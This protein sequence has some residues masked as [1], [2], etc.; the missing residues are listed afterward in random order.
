MFGSSTRRRFLQSTAAGGA[1]CGLGDL[2]FL[3][4]L[5]PVS[6]AEAAPD[7]RVVQLRPEIEPLVR[8]LEET[9]RDRLLEEV[10]ARI[11][12]GTT[13]TE[14]LAALLLAGVR[15]VQPR[16]SV[17]FKFHAV[18][19]VN[20]AHLA[21]MASPD[22]HRW[23]PIF[24][25]L[26][27]FKSSQAR[28]VEENDWTMAPVDEAKV[29]GAAAAR[30][31]FVKAMDNWD[32]E[33]ADAAV[34]GLARTAGANEVFELFFRYGARDFR[35]IGHKAI[36]VANSWRTLQCIGWQHAEPVLRSLAYALQ[37]HEGDNPAR[38]DTEADLP[39]RRNLELAG[40]IQ[41]DWLEGRVDDDATRDMLSVLREGTHEDACDKT[42]ELLNAG[43]SAQSVWDAILCGAG[44]LL[45]CQPGIVALHA[46]TSSN[47]LRFAFQASGDDQTRRMMLLQNAAFVPLFRQ[48]AR[49]RGD[50]K[51]VR[52]DQLQPGDVTANETEA[53]DEIFAAVSSDRMAAAGKVLAHLAR[54]ATPTSLIDAARVLVFL[55]GRDSHDYKFSSAALEDH[56]H[57]SP[58]WRE[59][60]LASSV[61]NL[62]GTGDRDNQLV[63]RIRAA[64]G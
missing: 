64:L 55:K 14:V 5:R 18:L 27:H 57:L 13:Y 44:E 60:Y 26:D 36:F 22:E 38:R 9:P 11:H 39:W 29:P 53:V 46:V 30:K 12:R 7:P 62:K 20:S 31:A 23:L 33:A 28:D 21:S 34:A 4:A 40:N 48:A 15:N 42:V 52:I 50:V 59:R 17:G 8:L 63:E 37:M 51:D 47:A 41:D 49:G 45:M 3:S 56:V 61:F 43:V 10:A 32:E 19:V 58:G 24:W 35:S 25:A 6:A 2:G 16:P 1:L 54:Q